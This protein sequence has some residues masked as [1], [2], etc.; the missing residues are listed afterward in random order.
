MCVFVYLWSVKHVKVEAILKEAAESSQSES[1][2]EAG[3]QSVT[4]VVHCCRSATISSPFSG[5]HHDQHRPSDPLPIDLRWRINPQFVFWSCSRLLC[6]KNSGGSR[7]RP[8]Y[9]H[10]DLAS[11]AVHLCDDC[12]LPAP[13]GCHWV[14]SW[15]LHN[16]GPVDQL[17]GGVVNPEN[18]IFLT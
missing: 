11:V 16:P 3:P 14:L 15:W 1:F 18:T 6:S 10:C 2:F 13:L 5:D 8:G 7:P 4:Q 9:L 17:C 12:G